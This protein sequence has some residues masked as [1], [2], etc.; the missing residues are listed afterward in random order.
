MYQILKLESKKLK[1]ESKKR[2]HRV[3]SI[4]K[5]SSLLVVHH[6]AQK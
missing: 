5:G 2:Y 6:Y 4:F 3:E 1:G